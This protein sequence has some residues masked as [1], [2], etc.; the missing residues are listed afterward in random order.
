M[1]YRV[2][3]DKAL[4]ISKDIE[5]SLLQRLNFFLIGTAFLLAGL[6]TLMAVS[7]NAGL[8]LP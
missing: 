6:A 4:E 7:N 5:D 1:L 3:Y 2:A 8:L